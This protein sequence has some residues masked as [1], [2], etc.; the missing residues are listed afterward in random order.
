MPELEEKTEDKKNKK[1]A[2]KKGPMADD[3]KE[4]HIPPNTGIFVE[5]GKIVKSGDAL[6]EG[7]IDLKELLKIAGSERTQRYIIKEVQKIYSLQGA[8]IHDKHIEVIVRQMFSRVRIKDRGDTEFT[9]GEIVEKVRFR[10]E[11]RKVESAGKKPATAYQLLLGITKVSLTTDSFLSSA[12][13]QETT[14]VLISAA[15]EGKKDNLRGLKE[16]VI[17]GRLIPAGTGYHPKAL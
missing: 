14:R 17:I 15:I 4:F 3:I 7:H 5:K 9:P 16:N 13:F 10:E 2:K 1:L 8:S 12:S 6:S 11:N